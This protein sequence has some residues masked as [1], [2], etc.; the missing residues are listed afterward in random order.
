M[1]TQI[2]LSP[3]EYA[4]LKDTEANSYPNR[5]RA[6]IRIGESIIEWAEGLGGTSFTKE[7]FLDFL[8]KRLDG[9]KES[10]VEYQTDSTRAILEK[11]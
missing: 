3:E 7:Q 6:E 9:V 1:T 11:V 2:I 5:L 4:A 10:L 8:R